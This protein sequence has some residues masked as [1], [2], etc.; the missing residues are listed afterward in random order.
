[1]LFIL[2]SS[3][4]LYEGF[5]QYEQG[6]FYKVFLLFWSGVPIQL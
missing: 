1:M 5:R 2:T 3:R 6:K 4:A